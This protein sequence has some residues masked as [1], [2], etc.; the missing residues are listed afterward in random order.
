MARSDR[1]QVKFVPGKTQAMAV[2][3]SHKDAREL[4]GKLMMGDNNF[5]LLQDSVS[6]LGVEVDSCS[7]T[8]TLR[9]WPKKLRKR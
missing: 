6:I 5:I 3:H 4:R 7:L 8:V 1:W 2:S 9:T